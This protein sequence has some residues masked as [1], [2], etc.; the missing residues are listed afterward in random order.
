MPTLTIFIIL[1]AV[2]FLLA[3]LI[4][5]RTLLFTRGSADA[6]IHFDPDLPELELDPLVP[7]EHLSSVIK[8][9][10]I[11]HEDPAENDRST[12]AALHR[13]LEKMYPNAHRVMTREVI[14]GY[15][16]LYTWPGKDASLEPV[17]F[18]A[19]QDV[20]PADVNT[21][22]Q[23]TH[24]PFSG[25]IAYGYI[26]GRGTLDIKSQL[27]SIFEAVENLVVNGF[28]PERTVMLAFGHDEEV[29][30]TGARSIVAHLQEKGIRLQSVVD[31]GGAVY[32]GII[33]GIKGYSATIG[34]AEK[35]YL[36]LKFTVKASGGHSS[37]PLPE[38][39]IGILARAVDKLQSR[40]FP[41]KVSAVKPL[42]QGLSPA[43]SPVMQI[44]FANLWL[45]RGLVRR[46][47]AAD[48]QTAA[49]IHTTTA[50]TIFHSGVKDN[51]LPSLAEAVVNFRILPGE[52]IAQV[53]ERIR[54]VIDDER[55]T[56]EP[57]RGNAWEASP[58][59]PTNCLAYRHITSVIDELF[60]GIVSAPYIMLGGTDAR[61]YYAVS[62][63]VYRF[64]PVI[65][66]KEDMHRIHGIN[67]RLSIDAMSTLVKFFYRLI[68]RWS[69]KDM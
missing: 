47:L 12:F 39:A 19:H 14:D 56:F 31:E 48:S 37:T 54:K 13:Q 65:M 1:L 4:L 64:N 29:L 33:P 40:Q 35:G 34:V 5:V 28:Q 36:S 44:A 25:S 67:E 49:T 3:A 20:V 61:N 62:S 27:I 51:V 24:P 50:P 60:P 41:Y 7:A 43:A 63:Q 69:S 17:A 52:S 2:V 21:L 66:Q 23:W 8:I 15:S 11:S 58:V 42:F 55:V 57:L 9:E 46:K 10:T 38:T 6:H 45:F 30:G 68:P 59:S 18:M 26:W 16:L 32:D 53:C 22:D